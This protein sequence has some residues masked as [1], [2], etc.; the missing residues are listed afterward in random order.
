MQIGFGDVAPKPFLHGLTR[1]AY[2]TYIIQSSKLIIIIILNPKA[3]SAGH[4]SFMAA[5]N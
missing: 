4:S 5:S 1:V 3:A 2:I